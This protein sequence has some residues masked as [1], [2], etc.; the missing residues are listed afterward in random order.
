MKIL[1]IVLDILFFN[2]LYAESKINVVTATSDL[3]DIVKNIGGEKVNVVSLSRGSQDLHSIE[4]K[5]SMVMK[6]KKADMVVRIG[7]DLDL[8]F[9]SIIEASKNSKVMYAAKGYLD[10]SDIIEKLEIPEGKVDASMGDIHIYG[11]PHYWL[12]P[13]NGVLI[14]KRITEK[15]MEISPENSNYFENNFKNYTEKLRSKINEWEKKFQPY[16]GTRIVTYHNSWP[17]FA[18]RF[19]L[20]I[21][22]HI[23]PKPGIPPTPSYII[24]LIAKIKSENVRVIVVEPYFDLKTA[25]KIAGKTGIKTVVLASSVGGIEGT[26]TYIDLFEYDINKIIENIK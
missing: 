16:R 22:G 23:E 1:L 19:N 18:R 20:K 6:V 21:S 4:P 25:E 8:W 13:E 11:N 17:Y 5:P 24:S 2:Y 7:M 15:L 12:D 9:Y 3:A 14:S 26:E 10:V